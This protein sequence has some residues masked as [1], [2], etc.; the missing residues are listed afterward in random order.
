[1]RRIGST[2]VGRAYRLVLASLVAMSMILVPQAPGHAVDGFE[3]VGTI[4]VSFSSDIVVSGNYAYVASSSNISVID[5]ATNSVVDTITTTGAQAPQG[6]AAIGNN[7]Y[8]ASATDNKLIILNTQTRVVSYLATTGCSSPSQLLVVSS[9]RLIANCHSSGNVQIYDVTTP[10][11]AGTVTTGTQPRGMSTSGGLVF[12]PNSSANT[13]TVVDAAATP[14]T[15]VRTVNVGSQP[16]FTAFLNGKIYVANFAANNVSIVDASTG[17]V[18]ATVAVGGN[19]QGIAPCADNIYTSDRWSGTTSVISPTSNTVI[20]TLT[21]ATVGAITHVMGVNGT[22]AY[23]LNFS[24]ASVSVVNCSNQT[25]VTSVT[26]SPNPMKMAFGSQNVYITGSNVISVVSIG[27][28]SNVVTTSE[29]NPV[30]EFTFGDS[31]G[32]VCSQGSSVEQGSWITLPDKATCAPPTN[33]PNAQLLG[34]ATIPN[35]PTNVAWRQVNNNWG[36]YEIL[37]ED[38]QAIA[39][40]MRTG[41]G[42]LISAPVNFYPVWG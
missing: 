40:Y 3:L 5:T 8:F 35:F 38:D 2:Q 37:G 15:A 16:E 42:A 6:A 36:A 17:S 14:P 25:V 11:I 18:L 7:V 34:W 39:V 19:P 9:T 31:Q 41:G 1:M 28:S 27:S 24:R 21:L 33:V 20:N 30:I 22:Y 23:F 13:M 26:I 12:V 4:N 32:A 29:S 10:A